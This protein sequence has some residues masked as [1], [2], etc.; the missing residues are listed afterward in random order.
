MLFA[1]FRMLV[2]IFGLLLILIGIP[3]TPSPIPF[4]FLFIALGLAL[5]VWAAPGAVRWLRRRWRW[6][7]RHMSGLEKVLPPFLAKYLKRSHVDQE[8]DQEDDNEGNESR[9]PRPDDN[10]V[11]A[12]GRRRRAI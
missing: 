3:L 1:I 10:A 5:L 9:P 12:E 7:D 11:R 2:A 4:G 6:F 8:E